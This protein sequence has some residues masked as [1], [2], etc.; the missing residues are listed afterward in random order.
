MKRD[1]Q[2]M[3]EV[4][5][6][7]GGTLLVAGYL[8][9]SIEGV[10][11]KINEGL[12][13]AGG[14]LLLAGAVMAFKG[15]VRFF[16]KR[17]SQLGTNTTLL[18]L[19][20]V[21]IL[22]VINYLGFKH[23]KRFDLTTEKMFTLSDQTKK[24]VGGLSSDVNV[25]RFSKTPDARFDELLGEYSNLSPHLK[26]QDAVDP[27]R[28][29]DVARDYGATQMGDVIVGTGSRKQTV[30]G[31]AMGGATEDGLTSAILKVM[32]TATKNVCFVT[33]HG[34]KSRSDSQASGYST[35]DGGLKKE[36][37]EMRDINLVQE[38]AVP[39]DCNVVVVAGPTKAFFPQEVQMLSKYLDGGGKALVMVDPDNDPKL[40]DIFKAWNI[41]LGN[42][43]VV[44]ASGIGRLFGAGPQI[45]LVVNFGSSPITKNLTG[46]MTFFPL[47]RTVSV[48]D[49]AKTDPQ[50]VEL[51]KTS[52]RSFTTPKL[53]SQVKY[54]PKTDQT[55]PLSLGVAASGKQEALNARLVVVGDSDFAS[56]QGVNGS[57]ANSDLFYN[58]VDW[59]AQQENQ[60]SIR[61]KSPTDRR[62]TMTE[63][64]RSALVWLDV[65][66]LPG[67]VIISGISIWW[68]RR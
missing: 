58:T 24:I 67:L 14:V 18:A 49:K 42:N 9:Y 17:S 54:D 62:I 38:N 68:K 61:P 5:A 65:F 27:Q 32:Q 16:S 64:Q 1:W 21:A 48:A 53:Q 13:I 2:K 11:E 51:L 63:A 10:F 25:M 15:I 56:N 36:G 23:H 37:Y 22:G 3:G 29:P 47:A 35:V 40:D 7:F 41:A 46:Q 8:R 45:P 20:V 33:G 44:D 39:S 28:Q 59:L 12:L 34:E 30:D 57:G 55:G 50:S 52:E 31:A 66:L 43:I 19:G 26:Y 60:I 6:I 4:T